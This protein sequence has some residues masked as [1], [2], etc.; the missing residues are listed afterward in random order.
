MNALAHD[1]LRAGKPC[2]S[3]DR[4]HQADSEAEMSFLKN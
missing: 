2:S 4:L 1:L 3:I